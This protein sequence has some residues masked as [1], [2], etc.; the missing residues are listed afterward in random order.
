MEDTEMKKNIIIAVV[1]V[2]SALFLIS[3]C[4]KQESA[5]SLVPGEGRTFSAVIEQELTKTTLTPELK[6]HWQNGDRISINGFEY[7]ATAKIPATKALFSPVGDEAPKSVEYQAF[8]PANIM[9]GFPQTQIY[10]EGSIDTPMYARSETEEL[11]FK[12]LCGVLHF[13][14]K[15]NERVRSITVN[16]AN[17]EEHLWG[18]F[19]VPYPETGEIE[20][21]AG[22]DDTVV[23]D[24]G[25]NGV[26]L[27]PDVP[28]DFYV[29]LPPRTYS[30]GMEITVTGTDPEK[31]NVTKT[32]V[33]DITIARNTIYD[34]E[35]DLEP[36]VN[37]ALAKFFQGMA[38]DQAKLAVATGEAEWEIPSNS[39]WSEIHTWE[40]AHVA[41]KSIDKSLVQLAGEEME[42]AQKMQKEGELKFFRAL[43][44]FEL[45][46]TYGTALSEE[47]GYQN[48]CL[49]DHVLKLSTSSAKDAMDLLPQEY[50][51]KTITLVEG[52]KG[53]E[54]TRPTKYAAMALM[55]RSY[56]YASSPFFNLGS[57]ASEIDNYCKNIINNGGFSLLQYSDLWGENA[58]NNNELIFGIRLASNDA[59]DGLLPTAGLYS[60]FE[61]GD[62]RLASTILKSD[63][64]YLQ[65]P[66]ATVLP[67]FRYADIL[68]I[69]SE[70][71]LQKGDQGT[72]QQYFDMVRARAGLAS[73]QVNVEI[74]L[75]ERMKELAFEGHRYWDVRRMSTKDEN[76]PFFPIPDEKY[77]K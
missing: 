71:L 14:I 53:V 56:L 37:E 27:N 70:A 47:D 45:F 20:L 66:V 9:N 63:K 2:V 1:A 8:F 50:D 52:D 35:W 65:K 72:A 11:S 77:S 29:S 26:Q 49:L 57:Y 51:N 60:L 40:N 32:T 48:L 76:N 68:L 30:T 13:A 36:T 43:L 42:V 41:I 4:A 21:Y 3:S 5:G 69:S 10:R 39:L 18:T 28:T 44:Y 73:Q 61:E 31:L 7:V 34:L 62:L 54:V 59:Y 19:A 25:E 74:I 24:C 46:R 23:L 17:E 33:M 12:N 75:S 64:L 67:V 15:G 58:F 22:G 6:I 38:E 16:S 55:A